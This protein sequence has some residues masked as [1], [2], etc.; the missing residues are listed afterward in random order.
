MERA[1]NFLYRNMD[2]AKLA[3][4]CL[5]I[6]QHYNIDPNLVRI[7]FLG[8]CFVSGIGVALYLAAWMLLPKK[9]TYRISNIANLL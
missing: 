8:S 7:L 9:P 3:G 5:G 4:V 1:M 2:D 6:S